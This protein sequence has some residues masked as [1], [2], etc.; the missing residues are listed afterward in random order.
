[1][2]K[3]DFDLKVNFTKIIKEV[4]KESYRDFLEIN[5]ASHYWVISTKEAEDRDELSVRSTGSFKDEWKFK[6]L[7]HTYLTLLLVENQEVVPE[8]KR[9]EEH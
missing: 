9:D 6:K 7:A 5:K 3:Y 8:K 2:K 4:V 1:M